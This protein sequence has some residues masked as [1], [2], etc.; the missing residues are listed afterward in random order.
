MVIRRTIGPLVGILAISLLAL[1]AFHGAART[2]LV[3]VGCGL[4]TVWGI[5]MLLSAVVR[6]RRIG[7]CLTLSIAGLV[8]VMWMTSSIQGIDDIEDAVRLAA[9]GIILLPI[10][11]GERRSAARCW[12]RRGQ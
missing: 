5:L 1:V 12:K 9:F 6:S 11:F 3:L 8:L 10:V 4:G 7:V 2:A